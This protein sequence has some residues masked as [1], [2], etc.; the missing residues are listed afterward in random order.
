MIVVVVVRFGEVEMCGTIDL[1]DMKKVIVGEVV[2]WLNV[3]MSRRE[4]ELR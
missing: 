1:D 3:F 4:A 2:G